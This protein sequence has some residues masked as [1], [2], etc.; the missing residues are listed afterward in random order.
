M[1]GIGPRERSDIR[2]P[3]KMGRRLAGAAIADEARRTEGKRKTRQIR[4]LP[5]PVAV[6]EQDAVRSV[7]P[8]DAVEPLCDRVYGLLP[9]D[10]FELTAAART[11]APQRVQNAVVP[12]DIILICRALGAEPSPAVGMLRTALH[13]DEPAVFHVGIDTAVMLRRADVARGFTYL[14][15]L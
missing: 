8:L 6:H 11:D 2:V 12:I 9:R 15:A 13:L 1:V 7:L 4:L 14:D 10:L 5:F 3:R